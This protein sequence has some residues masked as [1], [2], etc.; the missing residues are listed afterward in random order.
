MLNR[1]LQLV[2]LQENHSQ[3]IVRASTSR[4]AALLRPSYLD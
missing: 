3:I 1:G 4:G 2:R